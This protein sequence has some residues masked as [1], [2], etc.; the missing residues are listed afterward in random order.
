M[1]LSTA[2]NTLAEVGQGFEQ[3]QMGLLGAYQTVALES[4][5]LE[6]GG[7]FSWGKTFPQLKGAQIIGTTLS[8]FRSYVKSHEGKVPSWDELKKWETTKRFP[9]KA[10]GD[11][12]SAK[13]KNNKSRPAE[14]SAG[15]ISA[16]C[17]GANRD[18]FPVVPLEAQPE[19]VEGGFELTLSHGEL[20]VPIPVGQKLS[21][22]S[23]AEIEKLII[24]YLRERGLDRP[25]P[26]EAREEPL[27]LPEGAKNQPKGKGQAA[28]LAE[29]IALEQSKAKAAN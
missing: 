14:M 1:D 13:P 4:Y 17:D 6:P 8:R 9:G 29:K 19:P 12:L 26:S 25:L 24:G 22:V 20:Y 11:G 18:N 16:S 10:G 23:L 27:P 7:N 3:T 15:Q 28:R 21:A 2:V 5:R